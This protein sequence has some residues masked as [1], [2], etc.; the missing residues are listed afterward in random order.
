MGACQR[1]KHLRDDAARGGEVHARYEKVVPLAFSG[2]VGGEKLIGGEEKYVRKSR[3]SWRANELQLELRRTFTH[4]FIH[5]LAAFLRTYLRVA[6]S[7]SV[8]SCD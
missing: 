2:A 4:S 3:F 6:R 5:S 7:A 1:N 8:G